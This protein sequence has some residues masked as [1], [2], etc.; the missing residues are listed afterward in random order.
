MPRSAALEQLRGEL[1]DVV[2]RDYSPAAILPRLLS[3]Y[4]AAGLQAAG[5][6]SRMVQSSASSGAG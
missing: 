2:C 6:S 5:S 3:V 4:R 1:V